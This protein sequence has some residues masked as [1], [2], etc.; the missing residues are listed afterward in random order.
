MYRTILAAVDGSGDRV[1]RHAGEL[2]GLC[3]ARLILVFVADPGAA[4]DDLAVLASTEHVAVAEPDDPHPNIAGIPGWFDDALGKKEG[5]A[6]MREVMETLGAQVLERAE[7]L[8]RS[9]GAKDIHCTMEDGDPASHLLE[10]ARR[11]NA[12]LIVMGSRGLGRIKELML[13]SVSHKV[14]TM[15]SCPCLVVH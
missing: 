5:A 2:A 15:A 13:G 7:A 11:E 8:A 10:V 4:N 1:P 6:S 14:V 9:A 12:D 3:G